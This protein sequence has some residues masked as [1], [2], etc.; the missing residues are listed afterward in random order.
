MIKHCLPTRD[1]DHGMDLLVHQLLR[2]AQQLARQDH[3]AG[4]AVPNLRSGQGTC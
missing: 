1:D 4:G 2:L 3:H